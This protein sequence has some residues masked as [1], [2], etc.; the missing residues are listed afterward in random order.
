MET[1]L[2]NNANEAVE[3]LHGEIPN[4]Q[5]KRNIHAE[6][7]IAGADGRYDLYKL[8]QE[9]EEP[10]YIPSGF[11][12]MDEM[13]YGWGRGE[14]LVVLLARTGQGKSWVLVNSLK[15]AWK[16]NYRVGYIS[17]EMSPLK[18]GYR[19]DTLFKNFSNSRLLQGLE[20]GNYRGYI[21]KLKDYSTPFLVSTPK[22]F[23]RE[24][25][26]SKLRLFCK[27]NDIQVLG[28]DGIAYLRDERSKRGDNKTIALTNISEDLLDLSNELGIPV[29][30]VVQS[31]RGGAST[32]S[33]GEY[34]TPDIENIRDSDGI[35]HNATKIISLG[36]SGAGLQLDIK[37]HRDGENGGQVVYEWDI[38]RGTFNYTESDATRQRPTPQRS[39]TPTDTD[40]F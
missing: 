7:L 37:K 15:H 4:L 1:K 25:T 8:K 28:I 18:L 36:Q 30:V 9:E 32:D 27:S 17:P 34:Q 26:V 21:E 19:F 20:V 2:Q 33:E 35:A 13:I 6:D 11:D 23:N 29:I 31:N 22:D 38:D 12:E 3:Y 16:H 39:E 40:A 5:V 10:W 24:I 14:E